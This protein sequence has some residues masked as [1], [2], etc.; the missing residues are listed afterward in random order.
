[1]VILV[2]ESVDITLD[3]QDN[4]TKIDKSVE[5]FH[6]QCKNVLSRSNE[7]LELIGVIPGFVIKIRRY[8][9]CNAIYVLFKDSSMI[10]GG[11]N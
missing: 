10:C 1:M 6:F 8:Q 4:S 2:K 3:V 11:I 7:Q 5:S 9:S